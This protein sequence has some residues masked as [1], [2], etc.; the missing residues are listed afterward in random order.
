[1]MIIIN[2]K[3]LMMKNFL[4]VKCKVC[5]LK[6]FKILLNKEILMKFLNHF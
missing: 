3:I 4:N 1:M 5:I 6:N 2:K